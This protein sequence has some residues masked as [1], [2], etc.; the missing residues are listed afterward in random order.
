[1]K[2]CYKVKVSKKLKII[3]F[4]TLI[5]MLLFFYFM[6]L[7]NP[8]VVSYSNKKVNALAINSINVA[9][10]NILKDD[11]LYDR[12]MNITRSDSG[13]I[14]LIQTNSLEINKLARE[15]TIKAQN[16]LEEIGSDG[17]NIPLGAFTGMAFLSGFGPNVNVRVVQ[18]GAITTTFE[19]VFVASGINQ[20]NHRIYLN[21]NSNVSVMMP[22]NSNKVKT[23]VQLLLCESIIVGKIPNTYLM[24]TDKGD[25]LNLVPS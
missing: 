8:L 24:A 10:L 19:S 23:S 16:C 3:T 15:V 6:F 20:T 17:I 2:Y 11:S 22:V 5:I 12:I 4:I 18:I 1:M 9:I 7:V 25:M 21:I 13:D 14:L